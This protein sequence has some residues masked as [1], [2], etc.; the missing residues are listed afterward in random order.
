[1]ENDLFYTFWL[2]QEGAQK[3]LKNGDGYK[4]LN[5]HKRSLFE[6]VSSIHKVMTALKKVIILSFSL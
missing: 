1:M 6:L 3:G 5:L 2:L 4:L